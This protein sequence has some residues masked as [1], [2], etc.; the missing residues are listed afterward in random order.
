MLYF[1]T[2]ATNRCQLPKVVI[3]EVSLNGSVFVELYDLGAGDTSLSPFVLVSFNGTPSSSPTP[4][5][6]WNQKTNSSGYFLLRPAAG[7]FPSNKNLRANSSFWAVK[8]G[9][10]ALYKVSY[11][12]SFLQLT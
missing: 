11:C 1:T 2:D 8:A 3:N 5:D 12:S 4:V 6:L 7:N 9:A 10:I